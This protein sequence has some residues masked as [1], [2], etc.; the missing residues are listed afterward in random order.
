MSSIV[1]AYLHTST[2]SSAKSSNPSTTAIPSPI[3]I[4]LSNLPQSDLAL[5]PELHPVLSRANISPDDLITLS[6]LSFP[7]NA[8]QKAEIEPRP[9]PE[10]S[11]WILVDHNA[12]TGELKKCYVDGI[13]SR[14]LGCIDHHDDEHVVPIAGP[15]SKE[16]RIIITPVGSCASL[17][18]EHFKDAWSNLSTSPSAESQTQEGG[19]AEHRH[20]DDAQLAQLALAPILIDTTNLTSSKTT[21]HDRHAIEF[22]DS[23]LAKS[24]NGPIDHSLY[25]AQITEAKASIGGLSLPDILRKDYKSWPCTL[26]SSSSSPSNDDSAATTVTIGIASVVRDLAFLRDEKAAGDVERLVQA[27]REFAQ[28]RDLGVFAVMTTST[29]AGEDGKEGRFRRELMVL[30]LGEESVGKGVVERFLEK[31]AEKELGLT[32]L[33]LGVG[34]NAEGLDGVWIW[35]QGELGMSRKQ[36]APLLREAAEEKEPER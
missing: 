5:R 31:G 36:V 26:A 32:R 14:I 22:L 25:F 6:E 15:A 16:P 33:D 2:S 17:V 9:K 13:Q 27:M 29:T 1:Y 21:D 18:V 23:L 20:D 8:G 34:E 30:A 28:A 12:L 7:S 24:G 10:N 3:Y 35:E 11:S 19:K 4:P